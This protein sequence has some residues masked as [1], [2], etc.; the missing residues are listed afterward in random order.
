[1]PL[2]RIILHE[3]GLAISTLA[4]RHELHVCSTYEPEWLHMQCHCSSAGWLLQAL[5]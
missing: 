3:G 2:H 5:Q 1:M 4:G